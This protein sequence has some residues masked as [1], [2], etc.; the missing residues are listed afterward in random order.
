LECRLLKCWDAVELLS[1]IGQNTLSRSDIVSKDD[2]VLKFIETHERNVPEKG[3]R[4][5]F[6]ASEGK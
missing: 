3:R 4:A 5:H 1:V 2:P 6:S